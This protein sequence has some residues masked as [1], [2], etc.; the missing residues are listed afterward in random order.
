MTYD[1]VIC[2][3]G[4]PS[5]A[6]AALSVTRATVWNWKKGI[7]WE[8]QCQIEITTVGRL[9][10]DRTHPEAPSIAGEAA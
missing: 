3:F 2:H 8:R 5:K 9:K 4:S 7:S 1:D 10:A 6:A